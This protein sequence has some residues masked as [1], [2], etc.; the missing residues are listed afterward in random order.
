MSI[1]S[2]RAL[3]AFALVGF[4][5]A[6]QSGVI[7]DDVSDSLYTNLAAQSSYSGVGDILIHASSGT[8]RC[9]GTLI[10]VNWVLTAAHCL[11]NAGTTSISYS[12]GGVTYSA[13][14]WIYHNN[15]DEAQLFNGFDIG[16]IQ[17][18][19][20]ATGLEIA[21]LYTGVDEFDRVG[22]SV[23]FGL[24]GT[25]LTG[26][27]NYTSGTK[28]AGQNVIESLSSYDD[29]LFAD[30]D[31]GQAADNTL[32]G[33]SPLALE[34]L[35]APGDSGGGLFVNVDGTDYLAGVHSFIASTDGLT[36]SD[37][38]DIQGSTRI[39]SY[40]DWIDTTTGLNLSSSGDGAG[41]SPASSKVPVFPTHLLLILGVAV[42]GGRRHHRL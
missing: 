6:A 1:Y 19:S 11:D 38:G 37:Y 31:S 30:F 15:F 35:I 21:T 10:D 2:I 5:C 41:G 36:N 3:T 40:L 39:S 32:G 27:K 13:S 18:S 24:T 25:G 20:A 42:L 7:R 29:L 14:Q 16:L 34:Y 26:Y 28:R 33:A 12:A 23:G 8:T 17:L 4:S 22:T 9:S